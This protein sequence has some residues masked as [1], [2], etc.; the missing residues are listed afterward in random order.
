MSS[1]LQ[2]ADRSPCLRYCTCNYLK[3]IRE[4]SRGEWKIMDNI[5]FGVGIKS[6]GYQCGAGGLSL[7]Y[8]VFGARVL[9]LLQG[10]K[11]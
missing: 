6:A 4:G 3:R 5:G 9:T 11:L 2:S 8:P 1:D 10:L 7:V